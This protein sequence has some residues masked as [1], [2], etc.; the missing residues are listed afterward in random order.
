MSEDQVRDETGPGGDG[1]TP[2][3]RA[4]HRWLEVRWPEMTGEAVDKDWVILSTRGRAAWE[5]AATEGES[6]DLRAA[7]DEAT[8][9]LADTGLKSKRAVVRSL[10]ERAGLEAL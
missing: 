4:H 2:G 8:R 7:L 1:M 9:E 5:A 3:Q 6:R 10:R